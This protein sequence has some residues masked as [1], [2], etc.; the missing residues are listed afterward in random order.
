MVRSGAGVGRQPGGESGLSWHATFTP[1]P[2]TPFPAPR[3]QPLTSSATPA[4][5]FQTSPY[6]G[7][8]ARASNIPTP[9]EIDAARR[10]DPI[11]MLCRRCGELGHFARECLRSYDVRYMTLDEGRSG[12]SISSLTRMSLRHKLQFRI[13]SLWRV[14]RGGQVRRRRI[15]RLTAGESYAPAVN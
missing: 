12:L 6:P 5:H 10:K 15:L 4:S 7:V 9:M 3:A 11:P 13:R 2:R 1:S 8:P 14:R